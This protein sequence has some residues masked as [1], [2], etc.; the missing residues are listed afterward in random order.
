MLKFYIKYTL[1]NVQKIGEQQLFSLP[2]FNTTAVLNGVY[3]LE[4]IC[5]ILLQ[6]VWKRLLIYD[7]AGNNFHFILL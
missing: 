5:D 2:K 7:D 6:N 4:V 1:I 3:Y